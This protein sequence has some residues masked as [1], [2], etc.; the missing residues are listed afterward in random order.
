MRKILS[1]TACFGLMAAAFAA[2]TPVGEYANLRD[3]INAKIVAGEKRIKIP[4]GQYRLK[5]V[6]GY[7]M[8]RF[9]NLDGVTVDAKGAE[10]ICERTMRAVSVVNC[11]NFTLKGLTI[12]Y[13]PLPFT[14]GRIT[15]MSEDKMVH[16]VELFDG[17]PT[18]DSI[19]IRKY[20]VFGAD[21]RRL[22]TLAYYLDKVEALSPTKFKAYK[23]AIFKGNPE[24]VEQVG[25]LVVIGSSN[26]KGA[27]PH[28]VTAENSENL[29]IE[30]VTLYTSPCFGFFEQNCKSSVY[31][32]CKIDRRPADIDIVKRASARL[33]STDA[34]AYHC[35]FTNKGPTYDSC[36]AFYMGDDA[37]AISGGYH[38]ISKS[39]GAKLRVLARHDGS[40]DISDGDLLE[41]MYV[42]GSDV[43]RVKAVSVRRAQTEFA[44]PE[45]K[46]WIVSMKRWPLFQKSTTLNEAYDIEL[47]HPTK[48][49]AGSMIIASRMTGD[50]YRVV[51]CDFGYSRARGIIVKATN[52]VIKNNRLTGV[53]MQSITMH[54]EWYWFGGG[55]SSNVLVEGN[56]ITAGQFPAIAIYSTDIGTKTFLKA[57]AHRNI[58]IRNNTIRYYYPPAVFLTSIEGY[59]FVG[60]KIE[61]MSEPL[62]PGRI[63]TFL[64][65]KDPQEVMIINCTP[66]N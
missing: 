8:L 17:Y 55:H 45:E 59:T 12:D 47:E 65:L 9:N 34:D 16:E 28:C 27:S 51:N 18:T 23:R 42:D 1:I 49:P 15:A 7:A 30:G 32:N 3:F 44:T 56:D 41:I 66:K 5:G 50:N 6:D 35:R 14:Q 22:K 52:G 11:K 26:I 19:T 10:L 43:E 63:G 24:Q 33:A 53:W 4:E 48:A 29:R 36:S 46:D 21:T 57:G 61:K 2:D 20:E 40:M 60:N 25:D 54:P 62:Y 64:K 13:D 37:V 39:E 38:L 58:D 31:K